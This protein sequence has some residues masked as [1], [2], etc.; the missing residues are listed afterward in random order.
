MEAGIHV[1]TLSLGTVTLV[2]TRA[3]AAAHGKTGRSLPGALRRQCALGFAIP[4]ALPW[5][6]HGHDQ[7]LLLD[8]HLAAMPGSERQAGHAPRP[9]PHAARPTPR[10]PRTAQ[11]PHTK[12]LGRRA[13]AG[14]MAGRLKGAAVV[15][16][17]D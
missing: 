11:A 10:G 2:S 1:D 8:K 17:G 7:R 15:P 13:K 6:Q 5:Q 16:V 14:W 9:T 12:R 3:A 4:R